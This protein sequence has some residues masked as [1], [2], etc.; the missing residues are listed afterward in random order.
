MSHM[1]LLLAQLDSLKKTVRETTGIA[2]RSTAGERKDVPADADEDDDDA[3]NDRLDDDD[4]DEDDD[5][6]A[7][8]GDPDTDSDDDDDE[9][10]DAAGDDPDVRQTAAR[11]GKPRRTR[12][13]GKK[14]RAGRI[15]AKSVSDMVR[16]LA[17]C[18]RALRKSVGVTT[19]LTRQ[20]GQKAVA[21]QSAAVVAK[22]PPAKP[23]ATPGRKAAAFTPQV[24]LSK[25]LEAQ[26]AGRIRSH[27]VVLMENYYGRGQLPPDD[28]V[29][30]VLG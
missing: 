11:G 7:D 5:D 3:V 20:A 15:S 26:R 22:A 24:L 18:E 12:S 16:E 19:L 27:D 21:G 17:E 13:A 9:N 23:D 8:E 14:D 1:N 4:D 10:G 25:A 2:K 28:L 30:R 29:T 6:G